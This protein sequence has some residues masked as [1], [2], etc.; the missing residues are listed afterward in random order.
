MKKLITLLF[1][2]GLFFACNDHGKEH[3]ATED[4]HQEVVVENDQIEPTEPKDTEVW[5][6]VPAEVNPFGNN[7]APSDAIVLFDGT[8]FDQWISTEDSTAVKWILN[9]RRPFVLPL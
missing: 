9:R 7:G 3:D 1:V 4:E 6:P 2:S 8:N 5:E